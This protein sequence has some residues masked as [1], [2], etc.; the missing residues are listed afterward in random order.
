MNERIRILRK[1]LDMTQEE[2][3]SKI[4]LSRNF[5]AQIETGAKIP[6]DRTIKDI[7]REFN[8]NEDWLRYGTEPMKVPQTDKLSTY[9]AQISMG[10]DDFI[11]DLIEV[12]MELDQTS[13]EALKEIANRMA[14]KQ[15]KRG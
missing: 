8:I 10:N 7:C 15:N 5:I 12:Y 6:S 2:F 13:K 3:S 4:G 9:L 11:K 1:S 14:E